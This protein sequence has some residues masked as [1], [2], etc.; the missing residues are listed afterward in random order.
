MVFN[1]AVAG[2]K[3][4]Q[5]EEYYKSYVYNRDTYI[6][7]QCVQRNIGVYVHEG[8]GLD[9]KLKPVYT[10]RSV[11][12]DELEGL[13]ALSSMRVMTD[14]A[15]R[16]M[17]G[18]NGVLARL[19]AVYGPCEMGRFTGT[20]LICYLAWRGNFTLPIV[21]PPDVPRHVI[22]TVD[23]ARAMLFLAEWYLRENKSGV[24]VFNVSDKSDLDMRGMIEGPQTL[25]PLQYEFKVAG[26]G[27]PTHEDMEVKRMY[28]NDHTMDTWMEVVEECG[29]DRTPL[30]PYYY[31]EYYK[32]NPIAVDSSKLQALGFELKYPKYCK[33][34]VGHVV[35]EFT[36]QGLWP[37]AK[38]TL[39][40][41]N[42]TD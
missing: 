40:S 20:L 14:K 19:A 39:P 37:T 18:L 7:E 42:G 15:L 24:E 16:A 1:C 17:P 6:A 9:Y 30:T 8:S 13:S 27:K 38:G 3:L 10:E 35:E 31:A 4:D 2:T 33:E 28:M 36:K 23:A 25:Y 21:I 12:T 5:A 11:E 22:H 41:V 34:T 29:I 26:D 32:A